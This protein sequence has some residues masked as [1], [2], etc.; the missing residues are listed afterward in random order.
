MHNDD[1]DDDEDFYNDNSHHH[2]RKNNPL[3]KSPSSPSTRP[4]RRKKHSGQKLRKRIEKHTCFFSYF[5]FIHLSKASGINILFYTA[6][7][8]PCQTDEYLQLFSL[9]RNRR[10]LMT[11][12]PSRNLRGK[13]QIK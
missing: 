11:I 9:V 4:S 13:E 7:R 8:L 5:L 3:N 1:D 2:N 12:F 10:F 6:K